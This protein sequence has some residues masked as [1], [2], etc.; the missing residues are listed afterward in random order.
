MVFRTLGP[1]AV[2]LNKMDREAVKASIKFVLNNALKIQP[3]IINFSHPKWSQIDQFLGCYS[4]VALH[5]G[6]TGPEF[7]AKLST[8]LCDK[9]YLAG[10]A[11]DYNHAGY[12]T[13]AHK[14]GRNAAF[15]IIKR[16]LNKAK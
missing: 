3:H 16:E 6:L 9:F 5:P 12:V 8:P 2:R 15:D 13:A 11:F 4:N 10:E 14:T 1:D 7:Y